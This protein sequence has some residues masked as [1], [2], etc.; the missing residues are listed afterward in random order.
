MSKNIKKDD[1]GKVIEFTVKQ[2]DNSINDTSINCS[3]IRYGPIN[4]DEN[5]SQ[6]NLN[7]FDKNLNNAFSLVSTNTE[8]NNN[9]GISVYGSDIKLKAPLKLG[10]TFSFFY[11]NGFPL[12]IIGPQC[13][14]FLLFF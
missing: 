4:T 2:F 9:I 14:Y 13:N 1:I 7:N 8:T 11:I 12:F 3:T 5:C 6:R 10:K